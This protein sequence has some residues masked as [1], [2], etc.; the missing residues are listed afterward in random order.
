MS[1]GETLLCKKLTSGSLT[2]KGLKFKDLNVVFEAMIVH[3]MAKL[4]FRLWCFELIIAISS[5]LHNHWL[6]TK[7]KA[8]WPSFLFHV[9]HSFRA[10][11][12]INKD[13]ATFKFLYI[14]KC[15]LL[16]LVRQKLTN[17]SSWFITSRLSFWA[18][19]SLYVNVFEA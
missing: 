11:I 15:L 18:M 6:I 7:K 1:R 17:N 14:L 10:E 12:L 5:P 13:I 3:I 16:L 8:I 9:L 19:G 2:T 4:T